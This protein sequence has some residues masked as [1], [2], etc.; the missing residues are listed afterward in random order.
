MTL[1]LVKKNNCYWFVEML[2]FINFVLFAI[3]CEY[4][5]TIGC[6]ALVP[7]NLTD[8]TKRFSKNLMHK[9]FLS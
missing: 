5:T 2:L 3:A 9:I 6:V 8:I 1:S 7:F 4:F